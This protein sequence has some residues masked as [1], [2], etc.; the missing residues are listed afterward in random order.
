MGNLAGFNAMEV[1][2][3]VGM[4]TIPAGEYEA[5][6][7]SSEMK[8]TKSG[9]GSYLNLEIQILSGPYQNRRLFEKLNLHNPNATAVQIAAGTLSSICRAVN[10]LEPQD[11]S[12]L[13]MKPLRISV[14]VRKREDN[15]EM[16]NVIKSFKPRS[17]QPVATQPGMANS[18]QLATA[19]VVASYSTAGKAPWQK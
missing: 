4:D 18:R 5:C 14:G 12:E 8:P 1:E 7:V 9:N 19:D 17:S 13:H 16:T 3:N 11:S 2:P 15:G 10:V 6:I